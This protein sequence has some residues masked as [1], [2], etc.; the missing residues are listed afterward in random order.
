MNTFP[1]DYRIYYHHN[2]KV[3]ENYN[4]SF[5]DLFCEHFKQFTSQLTNHLHPEKR[6]LEHCEVDNDLDRGVF[7]RPTFIFWLEHKFPEIIQEIDTPIPAD[8][9]NVLMLNWLTL[10]N[11]SDSD[12]DL[13]FGLYKG[14]I[15]I[16]DSFETHALRTVAMESLLEKM[17]YNLDKVTFWSNGPMKDSN[18][19]QK[20][21]RDIWLAL[22]EYG[23]MLNDHTRFKMPVFDDDKLLDYENKKYKVLSLNGHST[24]TREYMI[25]E[26]IKAGMVNKENDSTEMR[27]SFVEIWNKFPTDTWFEFPDRLEWIP[28]MLPGDADELW[29]RDRWSP[30]EWWEESFFNLNVETNC[31][32]I[33]YDQRMLTEK[34]MKNIVYL[35]PGFNVGDYHGYEAYQK[36]LGFNLYENHIDRSYDSIEDFPTRMKTVLQ[37][38]KNTPMPDKKQWQM[39]GRIAI[40]NR[41]HFY[42]EFIPYL[43]NRFVT[44]LLDRTIG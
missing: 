14:H 12:R 1:A 19:E 21:I 25:T 38:I 15:V 20:H 44:T 17:G 26:A 41:D 43:E 11:L 34:W 27:Y 10:F 33:N 37:T 8:E 6:Y 39:M 16:D 5:F 40:Q 3:N 36:S 7:I 28:R 4:N 9:N 31:N 30:S 18:Y 29:I 23:R 35:S 32:W 24:F 42:N 2:Q 22:Q 13:I